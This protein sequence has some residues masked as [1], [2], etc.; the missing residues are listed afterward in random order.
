M[1]AKCRVK[2]IFIVIILCFIFFVAPAAALGAVN[3][4]VANMYEVFFPDQKILLDENNRTLVPVR[5]V[6]EQLGAEVSWDSAKN[7]VTVAYKEE[8]I[9]ITAG[10]DQAVRITNGKSREYSM[11]TTAILVNGRIMV[12]LRFLSGVMG[13]HIVWE[14]RIGAVIVNHRMVIN[15]SDSPLNLAYLTEPEKTGVSVTDFHILQDVYFAG[16]TLKTQVDL[17]N[18]DYLEKTVWLQLSLQ[19]PMG[20]P[21][22]TSPEAAL[23]KPGQYLQI[24]AIWAIPNNII[25]GTYQ[26][27]LGVWDCSPE[28]AGAVLLDNVQEN[29]TVCLYKNQENFLE[30][31]NKKWRKSSHMLEGTSLQANNVSIYEDRL[32]IRLPQ[33]MLAGGEIQSC[34]PMGFGSYEIRMKLPDVPSSITGFFLY[35]S[36][37]FHNEIDIEIYNQRDG[38]YFLTTYVGGEK[39]NLFVDKFPFDPTEDFHNYRIDY[40][41]NQLRFYADNVLLKEWNEGFTN[42]S[43]Y[44]VVNTWYPDWLVK[45]PP[46]DGDAYLEIDWIR[47]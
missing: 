20:Q 5:F 17:Q 8:F 6:I 34:L 32:M 4:D 43:M 2:K 41:P 24:P 47:Y 33:G 44:I 11:G 13:F 40:F 28:K 25:T 1:I 37:A 23:L 19:D 16:D 29:E 7:Q 39:T 45:A 31:N 15:L 38:E 26:V 22:F 42:E 3:Y 27:T 36:P 30:F 46:K 9:Y 21:Y 10:S 18:N 12:P 35:R 14:E